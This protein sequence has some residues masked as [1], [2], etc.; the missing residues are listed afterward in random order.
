MKK[1]P[2]LTEKQKRFVKHYLTNLNATKAA[3]SAGYAQKGAHVTGCR[4]LKN[5][6]V[7]DAVE[8]GNDKIA[9][10]LD[11]TSG[12]VLGKAKD[13]LERCSQENEFQPAPALKAL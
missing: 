3:I 4:L 7:K 9:E 12:Y 13:I 6:K 1:K 11:I 10:K 8:R 2:K 5:P